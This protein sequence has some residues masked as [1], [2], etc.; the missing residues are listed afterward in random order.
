MEIERRKEEIF[1]EYQKRNSGVRNQKED[2]KNKKMRMEYEENIKNKKSPPSRQTGSHKHEEYDP[3][4]QV[5]KN[6]PSKDPKHLKA[7]GDP[8]MHEYEYQKNVGKLKVM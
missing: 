5:Y 4:R 1:S 3:Y 7:V 2:H 6:Q 8:L